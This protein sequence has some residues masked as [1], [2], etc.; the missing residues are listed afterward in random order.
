MF[1]K[2][3]Q[4]VA[5]SF[6]DQLEVNNC[7]PDDPEAKFVIERGYMQPG[8][9]LA[10]E[11]IVLRHRDFPEESWQER[12]FWRSADGEYYDPLRHLLWTPDPAVGGF[13]GRKTPETSLD[14]ASFTRA[15][16]LPSIAKADAPKGEPEGFVLEDP[17][18]RKAEVVIDQ[19][20]PPKEGH[21]QKIYWTDASGASGMIPVVFASSATTTSTNGNGAV[22][23]TNGANRYLNLAGGPFQWIGE[24]ATGAY[25]APPTY[26]NSSTVLASFSP[27]AAVTSF[28]LV[29]LPIQGVAGTQ[30]IIVSG[31]K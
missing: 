12:G 22:S 28:Q 21:E 25:G 5:N 10:N 17:V 7:P 13:L 20:P 27:T 15:E 11:N 16:D 2:M 30:S 29:E 8:M 18:T 31:G 24:P 23:F 9:D 14:L 3:Y 1:Q 26:A 6:R 19:V 4:I